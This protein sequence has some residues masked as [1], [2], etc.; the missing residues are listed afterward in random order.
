MTNEIKEMLRTSIIVDAEHGRIKTTDTAIAYHCDIYA[1]RI[2]KSLE[3]FLGYEKASKL[4]RDSALYPT[5]DNLT[6]SAKAVP[7]W[8]AMSHQDRL[9]VILTVYQFLGYGK[10]TVSA[11]DR[12]PIQVT[13]ASSFLSEGYLENMK[14]WQWPLRKDLFCNE[15]C[16]YLQAA[17]AVIF[18]KPVN[19]VKTVETLC[20][21]TG[22]DLCAFEVEVN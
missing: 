16:G 18:D 20:R 5:F 4:L 15:I 7:N 12:M 17:F 13:T 21:A 1:T 11:L 10:Y 9:D 14:E 6:T 2:T 8:Q 19:Q 22:S 3:D